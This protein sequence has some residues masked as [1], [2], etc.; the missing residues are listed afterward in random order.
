MALFDNFVSFKDIPPLTD[1]AKVSKVRLTARISSSRYVISLYFFLNKSN[2]NIV[3]A[4]Q[5]AISEKPKL[6]I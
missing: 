4:A 2:P 6:K 1:T 5:T 3:S